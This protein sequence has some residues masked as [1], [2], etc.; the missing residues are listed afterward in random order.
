MMEL[1]A[2]QPDPMLALA[3][4]SLKDIVEPAPVSWMPQTWGWALV[5]G[6]LLLAL[7]L[8]CRRRV[9]QYRANAFRR[10]AL[11][12]LGGI[13]EL[14][15][16]PTTRRSGLHQLTSLLKRVAI[17]GWGRRETAPLS[18]GAW[19]GFIRAH[20]DAEAAYRLQGLLDDL[21]YQDDDR[22]A[23][24]T[25]NNASDMIAAARQWIEQRH[26]SA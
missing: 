20:G 5:A 8:L 19:V 18:S 12:M 21:E 22:L 3:L 16:D 4:R 26:V 23:A 10:E 1:Q 11:A 2:A 7:A 15:G 14:I 13:E 24:L 9:K 17:A 25:E 6:I